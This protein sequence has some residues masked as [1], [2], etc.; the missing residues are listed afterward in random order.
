M[1]R[2]VLL[3]VLAPLMAAANPSWDQARPVEVDLASFAFS[4]STIRLRAG[5][6]VT[7]HLVN[8][9]RGGHNFSA[10][11]FFAAANVRPETMGRLHSGTIEVGSNSSADV[12]L[13]PAAGH[14][15]LKCTHPLHSLLGMHG[16]IIVE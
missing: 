13:V 2:F 10:S 8:T 12:T 9:G 1:R 3:L 7:L 5:E 11:Q 16:E 14:Y 15:P 6:P 4:P